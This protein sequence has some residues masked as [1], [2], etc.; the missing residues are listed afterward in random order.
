MGLYSV[1][2][3]DPI[4]VWS[5]SHDDANNATLLTNDLVGSADAGLVN[6]ETGDWVSDTGAG[7]IRAWSFDG[8]N[9]LIAASG[10]SG[11]RFGLGDFAISAWSKTTNTAATARICGSRTGNGTGYILFQLAGTFW[12]LTDSGVPSPLTI[13][14]G[15][16]VTTDWHH[17]VIARSAGTVSMYVDGAIAGTPYSEANSL[18]SASSFQIGAVDN[19][20]FFPGRIDDV[21]CFRVGLTSPDVTAMWANGLGRGLQSAASGSGGFSLSR[22]LN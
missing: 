17:I 4:A 6:M 22:V 10:W 20:S 19:T 14:S 21:R 7:G 5:A 1:S 8:S 13:D 11:S 16:S 12:V 18:V 2:G 3:K 15:F 9:E